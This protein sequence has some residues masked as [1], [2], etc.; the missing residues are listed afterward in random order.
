MEAQSRSSKT[1]NNNNEHND[2]K[3]KDTKWSSIGRGK[4]HNHIIHE[5]EKLVKQM[6]LSLIRMLEMKTETREIRKKTK[7]QT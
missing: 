3:V 2:K 4:I 1:V 5:K 7:L 6:F